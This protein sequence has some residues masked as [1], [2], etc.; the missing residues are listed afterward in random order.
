[1]S[2][3]TVLNKR[4]SVKDKVASSGMSEYGEILVNYHKESPRLVIRTHKDGDAYDEMAYFVDKQYVDNLENDTAGASD[5]SQKI[6]LIGASAQTAT[7]KTFSDD[8]VWAQDSTLHSGNMIVAGGSVVG[9]GNYA[10]GDT[11]LASIYSHAE[12]VDTFAY[13]FSHVEGEANQARGERTHSEGL[14]SV[15]LGKYSHSEGRGCFVD[16]FNNATAATASTIFELSNI[17]STASTYSMTYNITC[18]AL[19]GGITTSEIEAAL[20]KIT[21]LFF[22]ARRN[23]EHSKLFWYTYVIPVKSITFNSSNNT[24]T[25]ISAD[26]WVKEGAANGMERVVLC[27]PSQ[28]AYGEASHVEGSNAKTGGDDVE[29]VQVLSNYTTAGSVA[30][31]EGHAT[32]AQGIASHA[33]G[34]KTFAKGN[35]SHAEGLYTI[36]SNEAEHAEGQYNLS[37]SGA[38]HTVGVGTSESNRKNAHLITTDGKHYIPGVGGYQGTESGLTEV[39]DVATVLSTAGI[40]ELVN[41]TPSAAIT[42]DPYKMNNLGTLSGITTISFNTSAEISGYCAMYSMMFVAGQSCS[43]VLPNSVK[44]NGGIVPVYVADRTYEININN[45]LVV[46][47]EFY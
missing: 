19:P 24:F 26:G 1:M 16:V 9:W 14:N 39:K 33:E 12:G 38:V 36:A 30:H 41:I 15:A 13:G 22:G 31:A 17:S 32:L 46:V 18:S 40:P 43:V 35:K 27:F 23:P 5:T 42:I 29:N 37:I 7:A 45:G 34:Q 20:S 3:Q 44:Y 21:V 47:G 28:Y 11:V 6:Y 4:T 8:N 10:G 2:K 25:F